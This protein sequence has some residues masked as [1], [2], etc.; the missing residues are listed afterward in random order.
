M[1][2]RKPEWIRIFFLNLNCIWTIIDEK[3]RRKA[4]T[5]HTATKSFNEMSSSL[6]S[7]NCWYCVSVRCKSLKLCRMSIA[8]SCRRS[9][10]A[11][12]CCWRFTIFPSSR[13]IASWRW[14]ISSL[15]TVICAS[16]LA[17]TTVTW[18]G[19]SLTAH[20]SFTQRPSI[21]NRW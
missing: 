14:R 17:Y 21:L 16:S 11:S 13:A 6:V 10:V 1:Y 19:L 18:Q 7:L 15:F 9:F 3:W 4:A 5:V 12:N 2:Y 8:F 20:C